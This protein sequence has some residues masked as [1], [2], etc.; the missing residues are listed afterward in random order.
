MH[1]QLSKMGK[2]LLFNGSARQL[3]FPGT[4]G[5]VDAIFTSDKPE[6]HSVDAI[7]LRVEIKLNLLNVLFHI[8]FIELKT[9]A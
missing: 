5:V 9:N 2:V 6:T 3:M 8:Q 7:F 1:R 4:L